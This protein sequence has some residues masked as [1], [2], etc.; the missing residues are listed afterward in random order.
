MFA[1]DPPA[2]VVQAEPTDQSD[3]IEVIGQ[4]ADQ[5]LKID[6][7]TYQVQQTPHS[8]QM[9]AVQLLRGLPAVTV[10]PDDDISLLGSSNVRIF[11][12]GRPYQGNATQYLRTLHGGDIER[13]EI[14]TNPSAQYAA[15][16]TGGIINFVLR[17][18]EGEGVSGT[19]SGELSTPRNGTADASIK[20]KHGHWTYE[21][22][23]A[24]DHGVRR[25]TYHKRRSVEERPGGP[26]TI[27]TED[28]GGPSRDTSGYASGK[29]SYEI[30]PKTSVSAKVTGV[31]FGSTSINNARFRGVTPDFESFTGRQDYRSSG[32]WLFGE[33][34][35]D[36]KGAKEGE[37]LTAS[38]QIGKNWRQRET[39]HSSFSNAGTL[40][41]RRLK[42]F[43]DTTAKV[44]WQHPIG[45]GEILS[46]GGTWD[47][48]TIGEHY[49]FESSGT[50]LTG[51][52]TADQFNAVD[53][54]LSAYMTFQQP[55]GDW[56]VMPG[57]RIERDSRR[58]SS[59][60][61]PEVKIGRT[62]LFPTLHMDHRLS[63]SLDLTLSYSKRIDR[64]PLNELRPYAIVQDVL[65]VKLGNPHLKDQSTDAYE[66][67]LH[68]H[69]KTID[70]GLVLYDRETSDLFTSDYSAI[71]GINIS[72]L[73]NAGRRRD[74]GAEIDV[75]TPILKR[76]K[77]N[78]SV[79][80]FDE[81]TPIRGIAGRTSDER[82][83]YTTNTTIQW[84]GPDRGKRPGDVAQLQW[85]YYSPDVDFEIHSFA[86]NWLSLSYTH[87]FTHTVSLT[88]TLNYVTGIGHRLEAPLVQE[89][90][91]EHRPPMF[92]VKLLK[93]F[94]NP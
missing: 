71:D 11:V 49:R 23:G 13:I 67:N 32:S 92:K 93:T 2:A 8:Q 15:E 61:H 35:F 55:I 91:A 88:G 20:Y 7:R 75:S 27:N 60:G 18:K 25:S 51:F 82:F 10:S 87:S 1:A 21:L 3:V 24:V 9:D 14:I 79:N 83:R 73:V 70:A 29:V 34:A 90:F 85:N 74:V 77:L 42:G 59:P 47:R 12:D 64:P 40:F 26:A 16:G 46:L 28:G 37:N 39:N 65:T 31:D 58:I 63:K 81:R 48:S 22:S 43:S 53:D 84:T 30:D 41:T 50:G 45:K 52:T 33:L 76:V 72:M 36:R 4:R 66:I 69:R 68:Y 5:A 94:G 57:I 38:L 19:L 80:L 54:Q 6:R 17:K 78:A 56:T 86:W 89:Y 62:D 44:D